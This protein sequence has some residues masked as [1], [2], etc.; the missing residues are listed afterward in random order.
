MYRYLD[1]RLVQAEELTFALNKYNG[2]VYAIFP[3]G[4]SAP[5]QVINGNICVQN[6]SQ[7][8]ATIMQISNT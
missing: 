2:I 3:N 4:V 5:L 6:P 8:N 1:G 7:N